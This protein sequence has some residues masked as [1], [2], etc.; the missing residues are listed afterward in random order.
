VTQSARIVGWGK[1][2][3]SRVMTNHEFESFL[4]TTDDWIV[5]RTGIRERRIAADD[6]TASTMGLAAAR[7]ALARAG[8]EPQDLDLIVTATCTAER[9]FPACS[10]L[11][12]HGLGAPH[13]GAFDVNAACSGFVYALDVARRFVESGAFHNV[14][15]VGTEVFSRLLNWED[16]GTCVLFGDG[17]GAVVLQGAESGGILSSVIGSDG[18]GAD[19]LYVP[20]VCASPID[21]VVNGHYY[22]SMNGAQVFKFAVRTVAEATRQ[23]VCNAGLTVDDIDLMIPHQANLRIISS[24]AEALGMPAGKVFVN[25]EKYGNTSS[26]SVPIALCEAADAGIL[27]EGQRIALVA[28][29]GGLSWGAMVLEWGGTGVRH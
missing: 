27:K 16:R 4:D 13:I 9:I 10:S 14:L 6:E 28:V 18:S 25:V 26:A 5:A 11:I 17:A 19:S 20:G 23:A 12:Q 3:P 24:A 21:P 29:G 7:E 22:V 1:Y 2:L 15:V 8:L